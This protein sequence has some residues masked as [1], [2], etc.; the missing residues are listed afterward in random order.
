MTSTTYTFVN[1][2]EHIQI[3]VSCRPSYGIRVRSPELRRTDC[4]PQVTEVECFKTSASFSAEEP[5]YQI[6]RKRGLIQARKW[7]WIPRVGQV[8]WCQPAPPAMSIDCIC[9]KITM[10][11]L[12][13]DA[14][15]Y[16]DQSRKYWRDMYFLLVIMWRSMWRRPRIVKQL[17]C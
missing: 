11:S 14:C 8:N 7:H 2:D 4:C 9:P 13:F 5:R 1:R 10:Q 6:R 15:F 3:S 12:G 17:R 16:A